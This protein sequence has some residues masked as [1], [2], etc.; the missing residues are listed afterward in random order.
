MST[1][2]NNLRLYLF[3]TPRI[4]YL[5]A[6][7]KIERRKAL[8]LAS[9]LALSKQ[10]QS[11][12]ILASLLW[13]DL[14]DEHAHSALRS[15]LMALTNPIPIQW[16][17]ADRT[18]LALIHDAVWVDVNAFREL[19]NFTKSHGHNRDILCDE[20]VTAAKKAIDLYHSDF[21]TGFSLASIP[22]YD[23]WQ[24]AQ[25]EWLRR[26][27]A[28]M[29]TYLTYYYAGKQ[30]HEQAI[31]YAHL[32]SSIDPLH[33]PAHRQL[34]RLF[35]AS[36]QRS[37]AIRQYNK[38]VEILDKELATP[39]ENETT[40]LFQAI[41]NSNSSIFPNNL[42]EQ[43]GTSILP[44]RP[45]LV[46]GRETTLADLK[47]RLGVGGINK[48][49]ITII[50]GWPGVGKS[51]T[52]ATLAHDIDI[53]RQFPD[54]I[55]WTSLGE[56][57]SINNEIVAWAAALGL[58]EPSRNRSIEDISAL[59]T[60]V[61]RDRRMLL[62]VDDVWHVEHAVPFRVGGQNC[63]LIITSRL[64]DI[65]VALAPTASDIY[66]LPVLS[67]E[68]ALDL[69]GKL[70]PEVVSEHIHDAREL[71]RNLEG[72]PLAI[73]VAGRLLH[74]ESRMGWGIKELLDEL[75]V[76]ANL[77]MAQPPT[78]M[79]GAARDTTLTV[80]TLLRRSTNTL[81]TETRQRFALLGLFVPK[82]ATFDLAAM[83]AAWNVADPKP[84]ARQLVNRGL[85][86][87]SNSGRF[88]MHALLV[89]HARSLLALEFGGEA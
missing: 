29:H 36:G 66:H 44:S 82:P 6:T 15:T 83:A 21:M 87:P 22:D 81:D 59:I 50:Q 60:A 74:A 56:F 2:M 80:A 78:D 72:L 10:R 76:G 32:W 67:E 54:G 35:A 13:P 30:E 18:T 14:D 58:H 53:A 34:M 89:L 79:L 5:G 73:H 63:A 47:K 24:S 71:I 88:Q 25:Q 68:S 75:R 85:L 38:C 33:E 20:C 12:A 31:K 39:P 62:I 37:E 86:E 1:Q 43:G 7:V 65:A 64:N 19:I 45:P 55:L 8:A 27:L 57:P 70:A 11:R 69:L 40:E 9:W 49:P 16:I 46:I 28:E 61:L 4:E 41:Q 48:R 17:Q 51:T 26:E 77:L 3:G 84:F 23:G 52:V 42:I